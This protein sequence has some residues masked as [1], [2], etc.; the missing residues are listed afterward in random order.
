MCAA[1]DRGT[2]RAPIIT[3]LAVIDVRPDGLLLREIAPGVS[4]AEVRAVTEPDLTQAGD[5]SEMLLR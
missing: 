4:V 1:P 3:D 5:L 2:V